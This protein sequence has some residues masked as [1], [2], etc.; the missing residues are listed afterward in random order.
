L[1]AGRGLDLPAAQQRMTDLMAHEGLPYGERTMTFNSR[2]A[3]ELAA[4]A[5]TQPDGWGI[6]DALFRAYF[7]DGVNLARPDNLIAVAD[8]CGL[9]I[10]TASEVLEQRS[11]AAVVDQDWSTCRGWGV[12]SVPTFIVGQTAL[13]GAQPLAELEKLLRTAGAQPRT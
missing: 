3:Q 4:W 1:F 5:D 12:T 9:S 2:L 13:V 6:H 10:S 11:F 7:V 8:R